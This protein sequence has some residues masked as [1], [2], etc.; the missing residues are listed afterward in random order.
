M[1]KIANYEGNLL[2]EFV[3]MYNEKI[4]SS[5]YR[6]STLQKI[7]KITGS[8]DAKRNIGYSDINEVFLRL[9][10]FMKDAECDSDIYIQALRMTRCAA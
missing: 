4:K 9:I 1:I 2:I 5:G 7:I 8:S 6:L 10:E 3:H